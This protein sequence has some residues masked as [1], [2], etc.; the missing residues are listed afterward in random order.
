[1]RSAL[2]RCRDSALDVRLVSY[3]RVPRELRTLAQA[4]SE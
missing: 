2:E 3:G 1:M 4:F